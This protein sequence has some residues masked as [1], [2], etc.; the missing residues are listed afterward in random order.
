M[1]Q[2]PVFQFQIKNSGT[3]NLSSIVVTDPQLGTFTYTS[4]RV[5]QTITR[6]VTGKFVAGLSNNTARVTAVYRP[7][8]TPYTESVSATNLAW[9]NGVQAVPAVNASL[10]FISFVF[11]FHT[12]DFQVRVRIPA[13]RQL[14]CVLTSHPFCASVQESR[15][16]SSTAIVPVEVDPEYG[17]IVINTGAVDLFDVTVVDPALSNL[18]AYTISSLAVGE[19]KDII[20]VPGSAVL[21]VGRVVTNVAYATARV[22]TTTQRIR[23]NNDTAVFRSVP[24][25]TLDSV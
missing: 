9:T 8:G 5:G 19:G 11:D 2:D 20:G 12:D 13:G 16:A 17:F 25:P 3:L 1:T 7:T 14:C 23:S 21:E 4:L 24:Q 18:A 15:N 22:G 6:N 10:K